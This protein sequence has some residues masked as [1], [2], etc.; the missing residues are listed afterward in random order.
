MIDVVEEL[1][2]YLLSGSQVPLPHS[3]AVNVKLKQKNL[4]FQSLG[5]VILEFVRLN[6]WS[7]GLSLNLRRSLKDCAVV[8]VV[9]EISMELFV[10]IQVKKDRDNYEYLLKNIV[11]LWEKERGKKREETGKIGSLKRNCS[12][13]FRMIFSLFFQVKVGKVDENPTCFFFG[14]GQMGSGFVLVVVL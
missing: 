13:S 14:D 4:T 12:L 2:D 5:Q 3:S 9:K 1:V 6:D 10:E 8:V 11:T 7:L